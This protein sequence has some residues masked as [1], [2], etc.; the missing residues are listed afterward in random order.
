MAEVEIGD[1]AAA[2]ETDSDFLLAMFLTFCL[3]HQGY[4]TTFF[5]PKTVRLLLC[6]TALAPAWSGLQPFTRFD[7]DSRDSLSGIYSGR[8][9]RQSR[10]HRFAG[11]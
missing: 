3:K 4:G 5:I 9:S 8:D 11:R 1:A 2:D 10:L 7:R 6:L